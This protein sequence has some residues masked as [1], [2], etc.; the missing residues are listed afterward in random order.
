MCRP[1]LLILSISLIVLSSCNTN[2]STTSELKVGS[3]S[4]EQGLDCFVTTPAGDAYPVFSNL[5]LPPFFN[6]GEFRTDSKTCEA[7]IFSN[8]TEN[9]K[10]MKVDVIG[11]FSFR[12]DTSMQQYIIA[13]PRL[14]GLNNLQREYEEYLTKNNSVKLAVENWF[15]A[16]CGL[17]QC[18]SFHW[19]NAYKALLQ[20]EEN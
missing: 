19:D 4:E 20:L 16:Q 5:D 11:L 3:M 9:G 14:K 17:S 15:R 18:G 1:F 13:K 8:R 2:T 6:I 10:K 7:I 12:K